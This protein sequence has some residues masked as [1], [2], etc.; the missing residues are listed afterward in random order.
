MNMQ[1]SNW[2]LWSKHINIISLI[3]CITIE[4][5][6]LR[7]YSQKRM[8]DVLRSNQIGGTG[9]LTRIS[10]V[11]C[12]VLPY[13]SRLHLSSPLPSLLFCRFWLRTSLLFK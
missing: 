6:V 13:G 2:R 10:Y 4:Y 7:I 1:F 3:F 12:L 11:I 9:K 8:V 5:F